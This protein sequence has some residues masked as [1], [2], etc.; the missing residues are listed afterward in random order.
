VGGMGVFTD[1]IYSKH[2]KLLKAGLNGAMQ[3]L[4]KHVDGACIHTKPIVS[5][6]YNGYTEVGYAEK[7]T[8]LDNLYTDSLYADSGGLQIITAGKPIT[9]EIKQKIYKTQSIADYAMCFDEIPLETMTLVRTINERS[10]T[11]NKIFDQSRHEASG[12][13]T[14]KNIKEQIQAFRDLGSHTK[15]I[16]IIQGNTAAD[17]M[18]YFLQIASQLSEKDYE[19]IGGMAIADTCIG[20]GELE[21]IEMLR[22]AKEISKICHPA[23]GKHLHILGV[24]SIS[25]MRPILYLIRSGYLNT[26]ER[27]SYDSSSHTSTFRFGLLKLNGGCKPLGLTRT[28]KAE[29]HFSNVY[30]YFNDMLEPVLTKADFLDTILLDNNVEWSY[31]NVKK[32]AINL[33]SGRMMVGYLGNMLHTYFQIGNFITCLDKVFEEENDYSEIGRL[34][35]VHTDNDMKH[36][37]QH[38]SKHVRSKRIHRKEN[39]GVLPL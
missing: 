34:L 1:H 6:L 35:M 15:V 17:M 25:R 39:Y 33:S 2:T 30:D 28:K 26:F 11:K 38:L 14:G 12:L 20:N 18:Q 22:G 19:N 24:G 16:L 36:W 9:P 27:V 23:V 5:L 8:K 37:H 4:Q 13:L 29:T 7:L 3:T 32:N 10:N 31:A 21:S